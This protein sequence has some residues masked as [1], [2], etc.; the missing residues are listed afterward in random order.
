MERSPDVH[1]TL[2]DSLTPIWLGYTG[3]RGSKAESVIVRESIRNC[4]KQSKD[5]GNS[6]V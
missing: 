4:R 3:G 2:V 6:A 5:D 1:G